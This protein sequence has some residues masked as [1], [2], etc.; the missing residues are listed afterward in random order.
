MVGGCA[1]RANAWRGTANGKGM[2]RER[3]RGRY[4]GSIAYFELGRC[5]HRPVNI[6]LPAT[7]FR[8]RGPTLATPST[9]RHP[10]GFNDIA[11]RNHRKILITITVTNFRSQITP[12]RREHRKEVIYGKLHGRFALARGMRDERHDAHSRNR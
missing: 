6:T 9:P 3:Q 11:R 8:P 7:L 2:K 5:A 4:R 12:F 1:G 10:A